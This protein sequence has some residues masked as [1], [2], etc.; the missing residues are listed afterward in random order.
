MEL[1]IFADDED[2]EDDAGDAD[3]GDEEDGVVEDELPVRAGEMRSPGVGGDNT[4]CADAAVIPWGVAP[5]GTLWAGAA[6]AFAG[7]GEG[8]PAVGGAGDD[9]APKRRCATSSE[10]ISASELSS[11]SEADSV[12]NA[13][14]CDITRLTAALEWHAQRRRSF[15]PE[16][17]KP[18]IST[19]CG[20]TG[21]G[22]EQMEKRSAAA[23]LLCVAYLLLRPIAIYNKGS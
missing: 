15:V 8:V 20:S 19:R 3:E 6:L 14:I 9:E 1:F 5:P 23:E 2:D 16:C 22:G 17:K 10:S 18:G 21:V 12:S 7:T 4:F 13:S 11:E